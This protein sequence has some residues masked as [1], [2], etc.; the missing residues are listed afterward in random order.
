MNEYDEGRIWF[1]KRGG[2]VTVGLTEKALEEIGSVQSIQL[3]VEGDEFTRDD[4]V[5]EIEGARA[6]FEVISPMDG[7]IVSVN[8]SLSEDFDSLQGD[9]LDEGWIFKLKSVA[10]EEGEEEDS[11]SGED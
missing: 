10:G 11:T 5:A 4:V 7:G 9:P 2:I 1:K 8:E 6:N 3:P